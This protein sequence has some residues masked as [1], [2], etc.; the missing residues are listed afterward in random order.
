MSRANFMFFVLY[1]MKWKFWAKKGVSVIFRSIFHFPFQ[2]AISFDSVCFSVIAKN[3]CAYIYTS[4]LVFWLKTRKV[5][6]MLIKAY[7]V[8]TLMALNPCHIIQLVRF[9]YNFIVKVYSWSFKLP[10][11]INIKIY[12]ILFQT[13]A[14][15]KIASSL[16]AGA[17]AGAV[18]KTVIA[19]LDRTKILFQSKLKD[20]FFSGIMPRS[21]LHVKAVP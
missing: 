14:W 8:S 3:H 21:C 17:S 19:P 15:R 13:Q 6:I 20:F 2:I 7:R 9:A 1:E 16:L 4:V 10:N 18:A 5:L 12:R 11:S